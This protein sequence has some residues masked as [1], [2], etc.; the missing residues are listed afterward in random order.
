M[1]QRRISS[2]TGKRL[3]PLP[4]SLLYGFNQTPWSR[5]FPSNLPNG[6]DSPVS[7]SRGAC[8]GSSPAYR[9]AEQFVYCMAKV[10]IFAT[11]LSVSLF[12]RNS[13]L[14][15]AH[16][17]NTTHLSCHLN[18]RYLFELDPTAQFHYLHGSHF[19]LQSKQLPVQLG[20]VFPFYLTA[21]VSTFLGPLLTN[22]SSHYAIKSFRFV[23]KSVLVMC[24]EKIGVWRCSLFV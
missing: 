9:S 4:R 16:S 8:E 12:K 19:R 3:N 5:L 21:C 23:R 2:T 13:I 24:Q 20:N 1:A 6:D 14:P 11:S 22:T 17:L 18:A 15:S 10:S 7:L